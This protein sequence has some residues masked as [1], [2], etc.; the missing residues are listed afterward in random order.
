MVMYNGGME[1]IEEEARRVWEEEMGKMDSPGEEWVEAT[2][3]NVKVGMAWMDGRDAYHLNEIEY[4]VVKSTTSEGVVLVEGN[5]CLEA[6]L[7]WEELL[8]EG[9]WERRS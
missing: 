5:A 8:A 1:N 3:E 2:R 7:S 4:G 9:R 6:E